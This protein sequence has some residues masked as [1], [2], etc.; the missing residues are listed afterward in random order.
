[1]R[2]W[3]VLVLALFATITVMPLSFAEDGTAIKKAMKEAMSG[4]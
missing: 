2:S 3:K 4:G 1:M